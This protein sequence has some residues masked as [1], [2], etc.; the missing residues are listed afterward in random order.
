[1]PSSTNYKIQTFHPEY[2]AVSANGSVSRLHLSQKKTWA[3]NI[4][5]NLYLITPTT[6]YFPRHFNHVT[7]IN[8]N[9]KWG[10]FYIIFCLFKC[11]YLFLVYSTLLANYFDLVTAYCKV[12]HMAGFIV[13]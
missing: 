7:F 1:M 5:F 8:K 6:L 4:I 13:V 9:A 10:Y 3:Q 2:V 11:C 12:S